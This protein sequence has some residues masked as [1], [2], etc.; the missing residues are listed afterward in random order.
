MTKIV[1]F[2]VRYSANLGDGIISDC[3]EHTIKEVQPDAQ[4]L[5]IDLAGRDQFRQVIFK[6]RNLALKV[7]PRLPRWLRQQIMQFV[8]GR[9]L[10]NLAPVWSE[11]LKDADLAIIGGGQLF[12]DADLNFPIK[13]ALVAELCN[14]L[15]VPM[16]IYGV[17]AAM[18]WT[19]KG[20]ELFNRLV[21][22]NLV[23]VAVRDENS[24]RALNSQM[25][26]LTTPIDV[27]PDPAV[28]AQSCFGV[29][30]SDIAEMAAD[31]VGICITADEVLNYHADTT[32]AGQGRVH[33]LFKDLI[34]ELVAR[35]R[36]ASVFTNGAQED[37]ETLMQICAE[38][39]VAPL[40]AEG[41]LVRIAPFE[42]PTDLALAISAHEVIVGHRLHA[43]IVAYANKLPSVGLGWDRKVQSFFEMTNR[44]NHCSTDGALTAAKLCNQID[45]AVGDPIDPSFHQRTCDQAVEGMTRL[46]ANVSA[47]TAHV[48]KEGQWQ[49]LPDRLNYCTLFA[50]WFL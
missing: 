21:S 1:V 23:H 11:T 15:N 19:A 44:Q 39:E 49:R 8:L 43:N 7:L 42:T 41:H 29:A 46:L 18:G 17:G 30:P 24:Q 28:I 2:A 13:I 26:K 35:G 20:R 9:K 50:R 48:V 40:L 4:V 16:A 27:I 38:P 37:E 34:L 31:R 47:P 12:S 36:T 33:D 5:H 32:V 22:Q 14:T 6:N 25:P 3:I 45:A 10:R